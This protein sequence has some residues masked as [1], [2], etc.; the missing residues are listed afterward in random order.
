[1]DLSSDFVYLVDYQNIEAI[2][3]KVIQAF[4]LP[5]DITGGSGRGWSRYSSLERCPQAFAYNYIVKGVDTKDAI[6]TLGEN[7]STALQIGTGYHLL[8]A[9]QLS[10]SLDEA[11]RVLAF[12]ESEN[13]DPLVISDVRRLFEAHIEEY[14]QDYLIPLAVEQKAEHPESG[15]TCRYDL[16]ARIDDPPP[17]ELAGMYVVDWKTASRFDDATLDGWDIDGEI[18][19]EYALW[20]CGYE[21]KYGPLLGVLVDIIGKQK[22]PKFHRVFVK[23]SEYQI[24]RHL[25]DLKYW[26]QMEYNYMKEGYYPRALNNCIGRYGKCAYYDICRGK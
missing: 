6:H 22:I 15:Y 26:D 16:I 7:P 3:R 18:L 10:R 25:K 12:M 21:A 24:Q 9:V 11:W 14:K 2:I 17:G 20:K 23:P 19:G 1:M 13:P 4:D 5:S 8:K